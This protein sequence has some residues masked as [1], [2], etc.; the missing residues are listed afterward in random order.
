MKLITFIR[1]ARIYLSL[2]QL[3]HPN[4][5]IKSLGSYTCLFHVV[6]RMQIWVTLAKQMLLPTELSP[7]CPHSLSSSVFI[8]H[9]YAIQA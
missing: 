8:F 2:P 4:A 1:L 9:I 7:Q 5:R 6:Q 3:L